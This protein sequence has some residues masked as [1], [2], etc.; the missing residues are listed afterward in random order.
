MVNGNIDPIYHAGCVAA[1]GTRIPFV[2]SVG[3]QYKM[4]SA[5]TSPVQYND[6]KSL[7]CFIFPTRTFISRVGSDRL[8]NYQFSHGAIT[9]ADLKILIAGNLEFVDFSVNQ[10]N[11]I[12]QIKYELFV[13]VLIF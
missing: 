9:R 7:Y 10:T 11:R 8:R 4:Y 1:M 3:Q 6:K 2:G 13:A 12:I 5:S